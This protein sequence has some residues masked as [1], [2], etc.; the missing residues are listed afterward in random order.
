MLD[1]KDKG[2]DDLDGRSPI[3]VMNALFAKLNVTP[4][5]EVPQEEVHARAKAQAEAQLLQSPKPSPDTPEA[6]PEPVKVEPQVVTGKHPLPIN[7]P[8]RVE[9]RR[10]AAE[11]ARGVE[12]MKGGEI[13]PHHQPETSK[14][15]EEEGQDTFIFGLSLF[16]VLMLIAVAIFATAA[17][18]KGMLGSIDQIPELLEKLVKWLYSLL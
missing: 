15:T 9:T 5:S 2:D 16:Q 7:H 13:K 6:K 4:I 10:R 17:I 8:Y 18:E 1:D 3:D 14:E 12:R 11:I